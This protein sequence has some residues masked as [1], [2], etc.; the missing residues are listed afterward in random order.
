MRRSC[1]PSLVPKQADETFYLVVDR[2]SDGRYFREV[3]LGQMSRGALLSDLAAG[4]YN[5]P[6][7]VIAFNLLQGW[8]RVVS[9]DIA[10]ELRRLADLAGE[11]VPVSVAKFVQ[12]NSPPE[13]QL[14]LRLAVSR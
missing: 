2:F 4:Q 13:R 8:S 1:S 7:H 6:Q 14:A 3:S 11:D 5:D 10:D 9:R 12:R